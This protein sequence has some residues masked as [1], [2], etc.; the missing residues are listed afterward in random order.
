MHCGLLLSPS[1]H[2]PCAPVLLLLLLPLQLIQ[3]YRVLLLMGRT[4]VF[5]QSAV[6]SSIR[7][8]IQ[9]RADDGRVRERQVELLFPAT[10]RTILR[11]MQVWWEVKVGPRGTSCNRWW[12]KGRQAPC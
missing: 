9:H 4:L 5:P 2:L 1:Q 8:M 11:L 3:E 10:S 7:V 6:T 12:F